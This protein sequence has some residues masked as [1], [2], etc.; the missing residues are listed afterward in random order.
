MSIS[1]ALNVSASGLTAER[2]RMDT[3]SE[4]IANVNTTRGPDGAKKV[5]KRKHVVFE[6][7]P[8]GSGSFAGILSRVGG[9]GGGVRVSRIEPDTGPNKRVYDP[10][11][12]DKGPDGY[13]E[14]P[15]LEPVAEMVDL[16][17]ATRAYDAGVTAINATKQM[18]AR[19]LEIGKA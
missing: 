14:L 6:E 17:T 16:I 2:V 4:N 5:Y 9:T 7:A 19:A 12:P 13:V 15:N 18:Q 8:G 11:H 3:I 10:S 1:R